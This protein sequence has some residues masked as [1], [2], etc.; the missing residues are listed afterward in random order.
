M[1]APDRCPQSIEGGV[2]RLAQPGGFEG[3]LAVEVDPL[4]RDRPVVDAVDG[5]EIAYHFDPTLTA[6]ARPR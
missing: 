3:F 6:D 2:G 4:A 1:A 5:S